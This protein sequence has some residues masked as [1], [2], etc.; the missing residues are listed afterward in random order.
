MC[1]GHTARQW[2]SILETSFLITQFPSWH[3]NLKK[4]LVKR[5]KLHFL[6]SGLA[7]NLLGITQPDQLDHHPLRGAIFESWVASEIYKQRVH[8]GLA[9]AL[10]HMRAISSIEV[11]LILER[12]EERALIETKSGA[13]VASSFLSKLNQAS[14]MLDEA[15]AW[16]KPAKYLI[17]GGAADHIQ[18]DVRLIPWNAIDSVS[19]GD[20]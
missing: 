9:P 20:K 19:W 15:D 11:D 4:R 1:P 3:G 17:H 5:S 12:G 2:L 10:H 16:R 13:T 8:A 6:D 7:C 14:T 18:S